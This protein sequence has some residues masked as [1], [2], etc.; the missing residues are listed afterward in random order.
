MA[1][2]K[3]ESTT[4]GATVRKRVIR[5]AS[6]ARRELGNRVVKHS[7]SSGVLLYHRVAAPDHD[8]WDLAVSVAHFDEQLAAIKETGRI[9]PLDA[10][11]RRRRVTR[12]GRD[13]RR[14]ALTFDDGYVDNLYAALP[15]LERQEAPAVIFIATGFLD[16]ASFWWDSLDDIVLAS[17]VPIERLVLAAHRTGLLAEPEVER[18]AEVSTVELHELLYWRLSALDAGEVSDRVDALAS[19][20]SLPVPQPEGRPM[21]TPELVELANHPLVTIGSHTM[22]HPRL[23]Q[24]APEAARIEIAVGARA[25]D[26]LFGQARRLFAYPFGDTSRATADAAHAAGFERAFT[27][28][29]R[30]LSFFDDPMLLPRMVSTNCDGE[31]FSRRLAKHRG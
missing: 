28:E 15:V 26:A 6:R 9:V 11:T 10:E 16:R 17:A 14:L 30:W 29:E 23:S 19:A 27:T 25:L 13:H 3:P 12:F 20:A 4:S 5:T 22:H 21:T 24:L 2:L 7:A 31:E 8:P 18:A 1:R